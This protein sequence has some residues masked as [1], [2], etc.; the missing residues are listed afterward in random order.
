[1]K[2]S[3]ITTIDGNFYLNNKLFRFIGTNMYELA[4]VNSATTEK[5]IRDAANEGFQVIRFWA[6]EPMEKKK[7]KEICDLV[8]DYGIKV[9]PVMADPWGYLQA[10][11]INSEW[12]KEDYKKHY[13]NYIIDIIESLKNRPEIL[14]WELINEPSTNSFS[15]IYNFAKNV[16]EKIKKVNSNHLISLGTIG[17]I[18]DKFGG[19]FSR[20]KIYNYKNLYSLKSLDALSIHD[21]SFNSSLLERL[22]VLLRF[23]GNRRSAKLLENIGK[24]INYIPQY[25]DKITLNNFDR[26]FDF[27][28]TVRSIWKTYINKN[29]KI[30]K[31]LNK[32]IYIGEVGFKKNM[33]DLRKKVIQIELKK[34]FNEGIAGVLLWSF[35]AQG[36]SND[37]HD[38]GFGVE[39]GLGAAIRQYLFER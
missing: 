15:D 35:E 1:M 2:L 31:D 3:F 17:G 34:Y 14:L 8:K 23:K 19:A 29:I 26:T 20:F 39:D 18:G 38:Y 10:Y 28:L 24:T 13:L 25:M 33:G 21:Y 9:I 37:G 30:A 36:R 11:K 6:F 16:S 4:N 27:P 7:L 32:P 12:Y 5:M 22:D